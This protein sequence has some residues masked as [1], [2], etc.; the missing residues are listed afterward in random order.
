MDYEGRVTLL[1][2]K[3][4]V[5]STET[6]KMLL[7]A[8]CFPMSGNFP[9]FFPLHPAGQG[10]VRLPRIQS[11][12]APARLHALLIWKQKHMLEVLLRHDSPVRNTCKLSAPTPPGTGDVF[13][14]SD[15]TEGLAKYEA[16]PHRRQS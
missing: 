8:I 3:A 4:A 15:V 1:Q 6:T 12:P 13:S 14:R 9:Y 2:S 5:L 7:R 11:F 16:T 10:S